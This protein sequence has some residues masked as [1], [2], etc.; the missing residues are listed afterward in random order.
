MKRLFCILSAV[1]I[2][3]SFSGCSDSGSPADPPS[4][5]TAEAKGGM[6]KVTWTPSPGV[7][8]WLFTATDPSLT[9]FNFTGLSDV[10][11]FTPAATPFY[12]CGLNN[13][14][15]Y[16]FAINGRTNNGPGGASS[17]TLSATPYDTST[18]WAAGSTVA[19]LP[20]LLGVGYTSLT[21]CS[22]NA[23]SAAGSFAAVGAAGALFT[24]EDGI[25]WVNRT[26]P[27]AFTSDLFAVAGNAANP[28][29]PALRWVAVG[30]GGASLYS[31]DGINWLV[32]R[33]DL[34]NPSLRSLTQVSG[35]YYAAGDG[36]TI[37]TSTDGV[38]WTTATSNT[39]N[40]LNGISY[41]TSFLAVGDSGTILT[42]IDGVTWT[43]VTA[44]TPA[45]TA[46]KANLRHAISIG[47][48]RV[49]VGEAG[50]IVT[51]VDSG[52]TW[53]TTTLAGKPNLVSVAAKTHL[54]ANAVADPL[55][56][57]IS[58]AQIVAID[59]AGNTYTS[60]NDLTT[61]LLNP[62]VMASATALVSSGF[63]YV[64]TGN[65]GNTA[66]AF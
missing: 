14:T 27:A 35:T 51:S 30:A 16:Y 56:G 10:N 26:T 3:F 50:T 47:T 24:S 62:T 41:G 31:S 44:V 49:A 60:T 55:L 18:A 33:A 15:P 13:G 32:G 45:T 43:I 7:E 53:T 6:V 65:A 25:S 8:Y 20:N 36:G 64:A 19:P 17:S 39:T 23:N 9:A 12:F 57:F 59:S 54:V 58:N 2:T 21:T 63:G 38:T 48:I 22:N 34:G 52:A 1:V 37:V 4:G 40:N 61:W 5:F 28:I 66:S 11:I 46:T 29:N 42:S